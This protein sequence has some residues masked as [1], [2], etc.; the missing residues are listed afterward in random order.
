[1]AVPPY[2]A[3]TATICNSNNRSGWCFEV[4]IDEDR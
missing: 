2:A 1:L 4:D 3:P